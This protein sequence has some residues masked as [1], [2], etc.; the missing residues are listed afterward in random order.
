MTK[1]IIN[2][3]IDEI[4][5]HTMSIQAALLS[6]HLKKNLK[7][8]YRPYMSQVINDHVS[9]GSHPQYLPHDSF[10]QIDPA[11]IVMLQNINPKPTNL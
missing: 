1:G 5:K 2:R 3:V 8:K 10:A 7:C 11:P 4:T 9:I 6:L